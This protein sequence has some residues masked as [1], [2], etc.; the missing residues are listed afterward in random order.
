MR[1]QLLTLAAVAMLATATAWAGNP[2][3]RQC[4]DCGFG[5]RVH[6]PQCSEPCY[7]TVSK[8]MEKKHCWCVETKT[9]CIPK[10]RFPWEHSSDCCDSKDGCPPPKCGR[11]KCVRLLVKKEYECPVCKYNFDVDQAKDCA[12]HGKSHLVPADDAKQV[13]APP[14]VPTEARRTLRQPH[15]L[16]LPAKGSTAN[17]A[18]TKK[19]SF[20]KVFAGFFK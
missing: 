7:P 17:T 11:T 19:K 12:A 15:S 3:P 18:A 16:A 6:C 9:I 20:T 8:D 1:L 5:K 2:H 13:P 14:L 10:I 4:N